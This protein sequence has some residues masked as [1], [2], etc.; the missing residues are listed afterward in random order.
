MSQAPEKQS[1]GDGFR[2][3]NL[4]ERYDY[5]SQVPSNPADHFAG[6]WSG[7]MSMTDDP[8]VSAVAIVIIP[9]GCSVNEPCGEATNTSNGCRWEMTLTA[10]NSDVLEYAYSKTLDGDC[11]ALG[12][13][14][15]TLNSDGTLFREHIFP[16][17]TITGTLTRR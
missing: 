14:T 13:G 3:Y 15:L 12:S 11:P 5:M 17:F 9:T 2:D 6:T 7:T 8:T 10:L 16:D 1:K 4:E